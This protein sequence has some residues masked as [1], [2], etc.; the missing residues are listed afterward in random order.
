MT[1]ARA[2]V[3]M[4]MHTALAA[5]NP[6][7]GVSPDFDLLGGAF[8]AKWTRALGAVWLA[9]MLVCSV[10]LVRSFATYAAAR[11][12]GYAGGITDGATDVKRAMIAFAGLV[13]LPV[14]VGAVLTV[15]G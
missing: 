8:R 11:K 3:A 15:V 4:V 12:A 7:D 10:Y 14:F 13:T 6:F 5:P 9:G 2:M 1:C